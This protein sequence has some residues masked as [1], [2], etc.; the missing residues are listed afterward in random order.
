MVRSDIL[1]FRAITLPVQQQI[2]VFFDTN[3]AEIIHPEPVR[4]FEVQSSCRC[5]KI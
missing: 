4:F 1:A 3:G 5:R 2:G